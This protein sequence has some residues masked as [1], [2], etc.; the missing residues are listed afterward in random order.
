M[1]MRLGDAVSLFIDGLPK[2]MTWR[3]LLHIFREV[4]VVSDVCVSQK[5]R[6]SHACRLGFVRFEKVEEARKAIRLLD[7]VK[8]KG[9]TMKVSFAKYDKNGKPWSGSHV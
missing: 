7:G 4:G 5:K 2:E 8:I 6:I 1:K 9:M 3:W